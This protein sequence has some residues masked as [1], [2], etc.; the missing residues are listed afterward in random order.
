MT[1]L[2][3]HLN[4][5]GPHRRTEHMSENVTKCFVANVKLTIFSSCAQSDG[6][7]RPHQIEIHEYTL[8]GDDIHFERS[9]L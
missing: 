8:D 1:Y 6:G 3:F 4:R 9:G 5:D 2:R 7:T